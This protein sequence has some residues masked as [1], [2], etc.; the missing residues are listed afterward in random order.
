MAHDIATPYTQQV[1]ELRR[2][3]GEQAP[4]ALDSQHRRLYG[5]SGFRQFIADVDEIGDR[6]RPDADRGVSDLPERAYFDPS[7][8]HYRP[9][10]R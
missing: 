7:L 9:A 8:G 6:A 4:C 2:L 1:L 5:V 3:R 10:K